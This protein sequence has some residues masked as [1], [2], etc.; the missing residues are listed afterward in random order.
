MHYGKRV[1][2]LKTT[3]DALS[4]PTSVWMVQLWHH[5]YYDV[6]DE[7]FEEGMTELCSDMAALAIASS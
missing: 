1:F 4:D 2:G 3:Q 7:R 6:V 5:K